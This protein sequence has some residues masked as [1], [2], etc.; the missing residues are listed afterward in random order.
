MAGTNTLCYSGEEKVVILGLKAE[1][2]QSQK[3]Q[4]LPEAHSL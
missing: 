3:V 2:T 4:E 1:A